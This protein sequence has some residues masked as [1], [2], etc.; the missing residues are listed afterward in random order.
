M[1][2]P[3]RVVRGHDPLRGLALLARATNAAR[4]RP[5]SHPP[6]STRARPPIRATAHT[7]RRRPAR[8]PRRPRRRAGHPE[9]DVLGPVD[10]ELPGVWSPSRHLRHVLRKGSGRGDRG[11]TELPD[12]HRPDDGPPPL[13]E[14]PGRGRRRPPSAQPGS[15]L[16]ER[17][18]LHARVLAVQG[19]TVPQRRDLQP[20][21]QGG[22]HGLQRPSLHGPED[23]R[24]HRLRC[25]RP[26]SRP[27]NGVP[28]HQSA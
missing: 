18:A 20:G 8:R 7:N 2:G 28:V 5:T 23:H 17:E 24:G 22:G 15:T 21:V 26:L 3:F 4:G 25:R 12:R 27:R 13:E 14:G 1:A 11:R 6:H 16:P 9:H 19:L 10:G